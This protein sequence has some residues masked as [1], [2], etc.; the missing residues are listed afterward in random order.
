MSRLAR[1]LPMS[2][3]EMMPILARGCWPFASVF[4]DISKKF[5]N[6]N[7]VY[8]VDLKQRMDYQCDARVRAE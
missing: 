4:P 5:P 1:A 7:N 6:V 8:V 2:P 3:I